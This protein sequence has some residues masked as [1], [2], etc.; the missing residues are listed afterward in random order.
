MQRA[1]AA[2]MRLSQA[3]TKLSAALKESS[4]LRDI[5]RSLHAA[6]DEYKRAATISSEAYKNLKCKRGNETALQVGAFYCLLDLICFVIKL[7]A[8]LVFYF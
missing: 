1:E 7:S 5:N 8:C 6:M 2:E 4:E 3:D